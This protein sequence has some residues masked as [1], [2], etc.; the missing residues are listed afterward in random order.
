MTTIGKYGSLLRGH[1]QIDFIPHRR[2]VPRWGGGMVESVIS[3]YLG[4]KN[5]FKEIHTKNVEYNNIEST[6]YI[7]IAN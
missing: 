5:D 3:K 6:H 1:R 4:Q 7:F 2:L